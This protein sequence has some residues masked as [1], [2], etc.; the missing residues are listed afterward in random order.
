MRTRRRSLIVAVAL[1]AAG[2]ALALY[3][4]GTRAADQ[5]P[6][7]HID[8]RAFLGEWAHA[9]GADLEPQAGM[10]RR[11]RRRRDG[12]AMILV[13]AGEFLMGASKD[14]EAARRDERPSH[15]VVLSSAFYMDE[16]EVTVGM[17]REYAKQES[18]ASAR[19]LAEFA[20]NEPVHSV[21][22][23]EAL[24]YAKW[25]GAELPTEAQW[26]YAA[27]A[28]SAGRFP[29]GD[30]DDPVRRNGDGPNDG[31]LGLAPVGRFRPNAFG[32]FDL[33]ANVA[34]WCSDSYQSDYYS[35][36]LSMDPS[37]PADAAKFRV[38]RGGSW[39][40]EADSL[41]TSFRAYFDPRQ[42][43]LTIG[44]RCVRTLAR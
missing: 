27:R 30:S 12:M 31:F 41:R 44:F 26:E 43:A 8:A 15:R 5:R 37:G 2:A 9:D 25:A 6:P 4:A 20:A 13:P 11:I 22:W 17:W 19:Q 33:I 40:D 21:S 16:T 39:S 32:L 28:G 42:G 35:R 24:A 10:P 7:G 29:W 3:L 34:E 23:L 36:S 14:D 18:L 38:V 1:L